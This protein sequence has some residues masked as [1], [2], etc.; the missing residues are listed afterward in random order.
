MQLQNPEVFH[1]GFYDRL[2]TEVS[3]TLVLGNMKKDMY[4]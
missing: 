2:S 1:V 4:S 3:Y